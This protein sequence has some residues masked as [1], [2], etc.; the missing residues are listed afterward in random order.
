MRYLTCIALIFVVHSTEQPL[1][2]QDNVFDLRA[3]ETNDH[4]DRTYHNFVYART[5]GDGKIM[6]EALH[7]RIPQEDYKEFSAG[8]GYNLYTLGDLSG[9][10]LGHLASASDEKYFQPAIFAIDTNGKLTGSFFF[11]YYIPLGSAGINQW[12]VDPFEFQFHLTGPIFLGFSSY[13]YKA[14]G[15]PSLFK[16]GGK[17]SIVDPD[18]S[19]ELA[20]R[21]VNNG[22]GVEFQLRRIILF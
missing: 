22:G 21:L 17:M 2:A 4:G 1:I 11:Q 20:I 8:I 14:E 9:Y 16:T 5:F 12:L 3:I 19:S 15:G 6:I 7:L 10:L 13:F 18:G